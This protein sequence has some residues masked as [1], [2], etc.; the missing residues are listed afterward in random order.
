MIVDIIKSILNVMVF[1][2]IR[3]KMENNDAKAACNWNVTD[4]DHFISIIV[5]YAAFYIWQAHLA[6]V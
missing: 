1:I 3:S 4:T 5:M 2:V 6:V